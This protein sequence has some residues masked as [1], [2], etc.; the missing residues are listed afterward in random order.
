[1]RGGSFSPGFRKTVSGG[2]VLVVLELG[3]YKGKGRARSLGFGRSMKGA[4][5]VI[6][7]LGEV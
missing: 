6:L 3:D 7:V 4:G 1:M 2:G 5:L